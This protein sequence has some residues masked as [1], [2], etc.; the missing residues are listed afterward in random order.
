[1]AS[2][3]SVLSQTLQ[4]ITLSKV[5]ELES[6]RKSYEDRKRA[7]LAEA[8]GAADEQARLACLLKAVKELYPAADKDKSL[9]NMER[10]LD[11]SAYDASIPVSTLAGFGRQLRTM[12]DIQSRKFSLA[13]LHSQL[14]TEWMN[15]PPSQDQDADADADAS[16]FEVVERQRQRLGE[17]VDKFESVVFEPLE[18]DEV[19]MCMFLDDLFPTEESR[20]ELEKL[21]SRIA[22]ESKALWG[23]TAP[24][25]AYVLK[26]TIRGLLTED[27]LSDE[28]HA[29]LQDFLKNDVALAEIADVLNMRYSD[30][31]QWDWDAG[32][33][34]IRV[35]PRRGLNGKYRVWAD[36]DILQLI[37]VQYIGIRLCILL[38]AALRDFMSNLYSRNVDDGHL[39]PSHA[40]A[41]RHRY[42]HNDIP[43]R[44][45][46]VE[47]GRKNSYFEKFFLSQ[48]PATDTALFD[49]WNRYDGD[50]DDDDDDDGESS[51]GKKG[52]GIKQQLLRHLTAELIAHRL[53]GVTHETRDGPPGPVAL[54]QTDLQWYATGL[55]HGTVYAV[56]RYVG[57][58]RRW[59]AFFKKYLEAPLNLDEAA[60]ERPRLGPRVRRRGVPMAHA[61]EKLTGE[62]VLF[63]MDLAVHRKT[64]LLLYRLHDDIWLVGEPRLA[65]RAWS[66]METFARVF[67]LEFNRAKTGSVY[68]PGAAGRDAAVAKA[69]PPGPVRIGFLVLDPGSGRWS[70]DQDLVVAHVDQLKKQ[71]AEAKSVLSWVQTWNSCIG[72]FFSHT[73]GE[74]ANCFGR[75]HVDRVLDTY[76]AMLRRLFPGSDGTAEGSVVEHVKQM[77]QARFGVADLPDAFVHLPEHL[78]GLGLRNPFVGL[79][80]VR[81]RIRSPDDIV[82]RFLEDERAAWAAKKKVFE[83]TKESDLKRRLLHIY[84][85]QDARARGAVRDDE[86][87][88]FPSLDEF[89]RFREA[90]SVLFSRCWN[91]LTEVPEREE[92]SLGKGVK[93]SL[94][95]FL[96]SDDRGAHVDA[97]KRWFLELYSGEL[98]EKYGGVTLVDKQF[99]PVSILSML[100]GKKVS[101]NMVL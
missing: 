73:F 30:L 54:V 59:L 58:D 34:G 69:L 95:E 6:R 49:R 44:T 17:L 66:S 19:E 83:G 86:V 84:P 91:E 23:E 8:D 82:R 60:D 93:R 53:R 89:A 47:A 28:K 101:W 81:D 2:P 61:S 24:F 36:D 51:P 76:K 1:M 55:S 96:C 31:G 77:I 94:D 65:A 45:H 64:G 42:Y 15:Q 13:H 12:L 14:L 99:L 4:N 48:L 75:E 20:K 25:N 68:L 11:Q 88:R 27:I 87:A 67:G 46:A 98:H 41:E 35:M 3:T 29:M 70:I 10:W 62:L 63:L 80:L 97:E 85:D 90:W 74:P 26:N 57:F 71:L 72:R 52:S 43:D 38:K 37:F 22:D 21:R 7:Y 100:R 9:R 5:R 39:A 78:G 79:F 56:M 32:A 40:D 16:S 18:T 33:Q 50:D 92:I